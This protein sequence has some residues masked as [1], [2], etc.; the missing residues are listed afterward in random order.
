MAA[1]GSRPTHATLRAAS[2]TASIAPRVRVEVAVAAVASRRD[3]ASARSVPLM[4][5]TPAPHARQRRWCWSAPCGRTAG[6]ST[7]CSRCSASASSCS[8]V[9]SLADALRRRHIRGSA[10]RVEPLHS[11]RSSGSLPS[12][13]RYTGASSVSAR[14]GDL[15]D[16]LSPCCFT[17]SRPSSVTSPMRDGV[18]GPTSRRRA[19]T[20]ASRPRLATSSMRSCDSR[21]Q[22]LVRRHAGLARRAPVETSISMPVPPRDRHL[23]GR[24]GE[25]GRAHV[26]DADERVA[27]ASAR[28][29]PRA[30]ASP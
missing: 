21:E 26:L 5:T 9:A 16:D 19:R 12:G 24:A 2:A 18:R 20:S 30:A 1:S 3:I 14:F 22:D 17:R 4:R 7:A 13:G 28:G 25:P 10:S 29:T 27:S 11:A 23:D 8:S 15:G 6:R